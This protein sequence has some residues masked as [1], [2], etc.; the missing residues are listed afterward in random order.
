MNFMMAKRIR[1]WFCALPLLILGACVPTETGEVSLDAMIYGDLA[2][3]HNAQDGTLKAE[4]AFSLAD[5][6]GQRPY[7]L[8]TP[9]LMNGVRME[10]RF[11]QGKGVY[12]IKSI[13]LPPEENVVRISFVDSQGRPWGARLPVLRTQLGLGDKALDIQGLAGL[14]PNGRG[15]QSLVIVAQ[16]NKLRNLPLP[17]DSIPALPLGKARIFRAGERDSLLILEERLHVR[18][19]LRSSSEIKE[20]DIIE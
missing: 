5:T 9:P 17:S 18:C 3:Q 4:L 14:G 2:L 15:R 10:K 6:S 1:L 7:F 11:A 20:V 19:R 13:Q 16:D 8:E 12:Y